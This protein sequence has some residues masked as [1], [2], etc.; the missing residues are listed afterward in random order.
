MQVLR[1]P[2]R[3]WRAHT[4]LAQWQEQGNLCDDCGQIGRRSEHSVIRQRRPIR[5]SRFTRL[6]VERC[7][8]WGSADCLRFIRGSSERSV[9][10]GLLSCNERMDAEHRRLE[11][12]QRA[13][14]AA[15]REQESPQKKR[16]T[17]RNKWEGD[18]SS[19]SAVL[20][21][22]LE[23]AWSEE[24][25][26]LYGLAARRIAAVCIPSHPHKQASKHLPDRLSAPIGRRPGLGMREERREQPRPHA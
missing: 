24:S 11:D 13:S 12:S 7:E 21:V 26:S 5:N 9:N 6:A 19:S 18:S 8:T 17:G 22:C 3:R 25:R 14:G 16:H 1:G 4:S 10:A 20:A 2:M 15:Q 23:G